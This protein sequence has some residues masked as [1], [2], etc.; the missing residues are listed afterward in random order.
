MNMHGY[1]ALHSDARLRRMAP[2]ERQSSHEKMV[3]SGLVQAAMANQT[4]NRYSNIFPYDHAL[5]PCSIGYCNASRIDFPEAKYII[6]S[7]PM[8][9]A[10]YGP[11]TRATFWHTALEN[12]VTVMVGLA[13]FRPGFSECADYLQPRQYGAWNL[14]RSDEVR[15]NESLVVRDLELTNVETKQSKH[16]RHFHFLAWPNYSVTSPTQVCDLIKDVDEDWGGNGR[17]LVHCSGGVGRS[18]VFVAAHRTYRCKPNSPSEASKI[19]YE[20]VVKLRELRH[21]WMVEGEHQYNLIQD[22]VYSI[23]GW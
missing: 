10:F 21:P 17:I 1:H 8:A 12:D 13:A 4:L 23:N 14:A 11:D 7:G 5:A 19:I 15:R 2:D 20:T 9:E 3:T 16:V 6:A 18:G 22:V